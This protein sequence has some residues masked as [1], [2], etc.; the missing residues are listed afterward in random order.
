MTTPSTHRPRQALRGVVALGAT[1]LLGL[2]P[3]GCGSGFGTPRGTG[4]HLEVELKNAGNVT[5]TRLQP[6]PLSINSPESFRVVVRAVDKDGNIDRS[7]DGYV[8]MS[9]KPGALE[10][11]G[12]DGRNLK[13]TNG[14]SPETEV[15]LV[16]G[17]GPTYI[18]ADDLGYLPKD[19]VGDP[20]PACA[21]GV[22]D[23]N[24]GKVDFPADEGCAFANDD[25]EGGGT[26]S[27]GAS[28]PIFYQLPRVADMRG[29]RC[30]A[31][32]V[33][34]GAGITPYPKEAISLD[35][36]FHEKAAGGKASF[37]FDFDL[38]VTRISSDGF[39]V[40]DIKDTRGGFNSV[41]T[42]NFNAPPR[43]RVCDR[44]KTFAG[45]A[46]EFFGLTQISYPTWTLE[47][48][49]PTVR[50]CL[51]PEPRILTPDD[52]PTVDNPDAVLLPFTGSLVRVITASNKLEVKVTPKFGPGMMPQEGDSFVPQENA[53]NCDINKDGRIDFAGDN[54]EG[55]CATACTNDPE[56]TEYSN[57]ASRSAF[58]LTITDTRTRKSAPIQ[59]D[60]S[61]SA[62]FKPLERKGQVL[63]AFTGT[64]HFFS[65]GSQFTIE[66]R[67]K[68][69]IVVDLNA[70]PLPSDK[71]CVFPRTALEENP[72]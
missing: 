28:P 47:E 20:P 51:V 44:L 22:D 1:I 21:N 49:D 6:R 46:T 10:R 54:P 60:A 56:C 67:C 39:Y 50:P 15:R 30:D 58:R 17:Y 70:L 72:Q 61:T 63:K 37:G 32:N 31:A 65:G 7:Y 62:D 8:R 9:A 16:N 26:Y 14:E 64:L 55:R 2:A 48:W 42:F 29:L 38:V 59:A 4:P 35:T 45:T 12:A 33:C 11:I 34:S 57:F 19:P 3:G 27:Q 52:I 13:L 24:D 71:A 69:D 41:F 66:A 23:D 68:D 36:G 53:T 25:T 5:G 18:L 43:M 40:S